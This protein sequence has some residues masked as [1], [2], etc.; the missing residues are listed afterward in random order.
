MPLSLSG[1]PRTTAKRGLE[2][3][4]LRLMPT[5]PGND[6]ICAVDMV[7]AAKRVGDLRVLDEVR[8]LCVKILP[9]QGDQLCKPGRRKGAS[10]RATSRLARMY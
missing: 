3:R 8:V 9:R 6:S 5:L 10:L 1:L 2:Q 7:E 4:Q